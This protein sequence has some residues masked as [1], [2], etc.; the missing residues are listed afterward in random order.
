MSVGPFENDLGD[1]PGVGVGLPP[2]VGVD[3]GAGVDVGVSVG[4]DVGTTIDNTPLNIPS[5][6]YSPNKFISMP[7]TPFPDNVS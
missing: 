1:I 2:G 5:G 4:V 7:S 6:M 3:V